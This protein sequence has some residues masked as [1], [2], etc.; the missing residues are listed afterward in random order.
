[1]KPQKEHGRDFFF[2]K[3]GQY[4]GSRLVWVRVFSICGMHLSY[5]VVKS[6]NLG[7]RALWSVRSVESNTPCPGAGA[8]RV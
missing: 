6:P 5:K 2:S 1:M 7:A 8:A 3:R 4:G